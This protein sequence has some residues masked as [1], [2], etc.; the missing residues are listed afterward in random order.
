[1]GWQIGIFNRCEAC[2]ALFDLLRRPNIG[3]IKMENLCDLE[4]VE[5]RNLDL[6]GIG[7]WDLRVW[8]G[9]GGWRIG[10]CGRCEAG[11]MTNK[12]AGALSSAVLHCTD[13]S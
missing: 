5:M 11:S 10:V 2:I 6:W 9:W 13:T 8:M 12:G 1:M 3:M 7:V 4:L